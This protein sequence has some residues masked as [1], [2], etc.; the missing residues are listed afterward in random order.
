MT[1]S[2]NLMQSAARTLLG[3]PINR[4]Q[5]MT[6]SANLMPELDSFIDVITLV[7]KNGRPHSYA[8]TRRGYHV[9]IEVMSHQDIRDALKVE[10]IWHGK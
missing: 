4:P 6:G 1:G 5:P 2:A 8:R 10:D 3:H 7:E 9:P